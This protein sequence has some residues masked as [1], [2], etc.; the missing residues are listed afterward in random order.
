MMSEGTKKVLI[1][2]CGIVIVTLAVLAYNRWLQQTQPSLKK[3][4]DGRM[5]EWI[6]P[7][8]FILK[9][10]GK[11]VVISVETKDKLRASLGVSD[12]V[13][14]QAVASTQYID[15]QLRLFIVYY[16]V[17]SCEADGQK[18]Y[19]R[20]V[21]LRSK[22]LPELARLNQQLNELARTGTKEDRSKAVENAKQ[23]NARATQINESIKAK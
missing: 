2:T 1:I 9:Y 11:K 22:D 20:L 14:Q 18:M 13:I 3:C 7:E 19:D 15:Q 10:S 8:T 23:V 16:N 12:D 6:V 5:V 21:E 17:R 4:G